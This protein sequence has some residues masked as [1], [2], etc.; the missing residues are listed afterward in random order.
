MIPSV[1][2]AVA[3]LL[4]ALGALPPLSQSV[5]AD[6]TFDFTLSRAA[7]T[8]A[9]V[10]DSSGVL[11]RTLWAD[12]HFNKAGTYAAVWDDLDD[13][14]AAVSGGTHT[15]K[16]MAHNV[17]HVWEGVLGNTSDNFSGE[18]VHSNFN[19]ATTI[20]FSGST[21]SYAVGYSENQP[22]FYSFSTA[23]P[24]QVAVRY[25][26]CPTGGN[27]MGFRFSD[28]DGSRVYFACPKTQDSA[29]DLWTLPGAVCAFDPATGAVSN[30]TNGYAI[31]EKWHPFS[32]GVRVGTQPGIS[33][34]A[35]QKNGGGYLAVSVGAD[36]TVYLLDKVTGSVVK[37]I[38][39]SAPG[40]L[41][42]DNADNLWVASGTS[43][44]RYTNLSGTP[45]A[46]TTITGFQKPLAMTVSPSGSNQPDLL[47]VADG[48]S[49]Q[50]VKAYGMGG[51]AQ[52]ALGQAGGYASSPTVTT[53]KF[54]FMEAE[55]F[56]SSE[57]DAETTSIAFQPDG[58]FWLI[59][60]M[61][62]RMLR[63][64]LSAT[65]G[66]AP[67][68]ETQ[69]AYRGVAYVTAVDR[70]NPTRVFSCSRGKW[71]EYQVDYTK[72]LAPDNGSWTLV[73]NWSRALPAGVTDFA[74]QGFMSVATLSNGRTYGL[75]RDNTLT[76]PQRA[77]VFELPSSGNLRD[78]GVTVPVYFVAGDGS[79]TSQSLS[80]NTITFSRQTLAGFDASHNPLW[81]AASV[82]ASAPA[83]AGVNPRS[84]SNGNGPNI[85]TTAANRLVFFDHSKND[86]MHL[87]GIDLGGGASGWTW[88][89]APAIPG[90]VPLI[91]DGSYD[92]SPNIHYGGGLCDAAGNTIVFTYKGEFWSNSQANQL[93]NY[94]DS[95]LFIGQFGTPGNGPAKTPQGAAG[96]LAMPYVVVHGGKTYVYTND[97]SVHGGV[98]RWRI[99]GLNTVATLSGTGAPGSAVT[100]SGAAPVGSLPSV[101]G[102]PLRP[103]QV[104]ATGS[105]GHV[106]LEWTP[107]SGASYYQVRRSENSLH[108]YQI[109][110]TGVFQTSF[111]DLHVDN[112][113][114][115][116]YR[117]NGVNEKGA[118]GVSIQTVGIPSAGTNVYEAEDGVLAGTNARNDLWASGKLQVA[119]TG[120]G[121]I[122]ISGIDGGAGGSATMRMRYSHNLSTNWNS[123]AYLTINGTA[124]ALPV[125]PPT[126]GWQGGVVSPYDDVD[127]V[128]SLNPGPT[129]TLVLGKGPC[130]DKFTFMVDTPFLGSP[131]EIPAG[132]GTLNIEA[133]DYNHGGQGVA[134]NDTATANHNS[135]YRAFDGVG[136]G[137]SSTASNGFHIGY[138][139][140]NEWLDYTVSVP[141]TKTYTLTI[142]A[143]TNQNG[144]TLRVEDETGANLT[145]TVNIANTGSYYTYAPHA[146]AVNLTAGTHIL[147]VYNL[148]GGYNLDRFTISH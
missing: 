107:S 26:G 88:Q 85:A 108:G 126:G 23:T 42:F 62:C 19:F 135:C 13:S 43:V 118:G 77:R 3:C 119:N 127:I 22:A 73:R 69:I 66:V 31:Y 128:V 33:G 34:L 57:P 123:S 60:P 37:A 139:N 50:Q 95:G 92:N 56:G 140:T 17:N 4:T 131:M 76:S 97:E 106:H 1:R 111:N 64:G 112:G 89:S 28:G 41:A 25:T 120:T 21:G 10:Y 87:G 15:I 5:R 143:G 124:V 18:T 27:D 20:C 103:D 2:L 71:L 147:R 8:S 86:G 39:V 101:S 109:I 122:T 75:A 78:T 46:G 45:V 98:H 7:R 115:Y 91:G 137:Q 29:T 83:V 6:T 90:Q 96:N 49:S 130:V 79:L 80:G 148:S 63:F 55:A 142:H 24:N 74:F 94:H 51:V 146:V 68:Y 72:T 59:D 47:L 129:N 141:A 16:V 44:V 138:I 67:S 65:A 48:G 114:T 132:S 121:S 144:K 30:F 82:I 38:A 61:N 136:I 32:N 84:G 11:V 35:V 99:D 134:Y 81:N 12:A 133:E 110:A 54:W 9:G 53:D 105:D 104:N 145:G 125:L 70:N 14:G 117:V 113:T 40:A 102:A 58:S 116:Y 36:D 93:M 52:W 100:L